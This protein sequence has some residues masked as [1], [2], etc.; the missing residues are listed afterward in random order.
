[1]CR[2][3]DAGSH[4]RIQRFARPGFTCPDFIAEIIRRADAGFIVLP[5]RWDAWR[6]FG[7]LTRDRR[8]VHDFVACIRAAMT[9]R[10][11]TPP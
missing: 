5:R 10:R 4:V 6:T 9:T 11:I 2:R 8:L 1:L 7:W 3:T